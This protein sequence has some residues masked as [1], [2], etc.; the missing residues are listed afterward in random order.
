MVYT[1]DGKLALPYSNETVLGQRISSVEDQLEDMGF[2]NVQRSEKKSLA[3]F[4]GTQ[5]S[6]T[7]VRMLVNGEDTF[8]IGDRFAP[9]VSIVLEYYD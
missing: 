6:Y 8:N 3:T 1:P 2:S 5:S 7:V 4:I 9:D